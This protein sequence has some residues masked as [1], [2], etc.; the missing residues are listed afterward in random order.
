MIGN[1]YSSLLNK[2]ILGIRDPLNI[3][4]KNKT[5]YKGYSGIILQG[6]SGSGK[7]QLIQRFAYDC[8]EVL[9]F[10]TISC[11]ELVHKVVGDSEKRIN[12]LFYQAKN[13]A[14]VL[15]LIDNIDIIFGNSYSN[16]TVNKNKKEITE[17]RP[18]N[19]KK[20]ANDLVDEIYTNARTS[21]NAIDR[22]LSTLLIELD[23]INSQSKLKV[24]ENSEPFSFFQLKQ[25]YDSDLNP[26]IVK[27]NINSPVIVIATTKSHSSI[28]P[29]LLRPGRL[30]EHISI[31][32]LTVEDCDLMI[33]YELSRFQ[34]NDTPNPS[35]EYSQFIKEISTI[36]INTSRLTT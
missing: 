16:E 17:W 25:L 15:L 20:R 3:S 13:M 21:N 5:I 36:C 12:Q 2:L 29:S 31:P 7:T 8:R 30:E 35:H 14:P 4:I 11:S 28:D 27:S 10:M 32:P 24:Y 18:N 6:A 23:G 9:R 34:I 22:I 33:G 26:E 19:K 1:Y